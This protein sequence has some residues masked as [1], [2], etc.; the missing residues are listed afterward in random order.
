MLLFYAT[1]VATMPLLAA[2]SVLPLETLAA[3][4]DSATVVGKGTMLILL[5]ETLG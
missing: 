5:V 2:E 3:A 4:F 1:L